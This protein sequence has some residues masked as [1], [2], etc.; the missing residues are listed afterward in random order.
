MV[1]SQIKENIEMRKFWAMAVLAAL[2]LAG[3]R[4]AGAKPKSFI[5]A[6]INGQK[7]KV[8]GKGK[9][10]D[11]CLTGIY[12]A[13]NGFF[14]FDALECRHG[15]A[16]PKGHIQ[17][18]FFTCSIPPLGQPTPCPIATYT[19]FTFKHR[20]L[21]SEKDWAA[22][23]DGAN[24]TSTVTIVLDS[25]DGTILHGRFSGAYDTPAEAGNPPA[26]ISGEGAFAVPMQAQ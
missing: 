8:T 21:L 2:V 11:K 18:V 9:V 13:T 20:A 25:F 1:R 26:L 7:L 16:V 5:F 17:F 6:K 12:D 23:V 4:E 22:T 10:T 14:A 19:E 15:R 3:S 24:L